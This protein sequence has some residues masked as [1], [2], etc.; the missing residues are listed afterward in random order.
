MSNSQPCILLCSESI[1]IV[2]DLLF[3]LATRRETGC[4]KR[5]RFTL[6]S[7]SGTT[8]HVSHIMFVSMLNPMLM[9]PAMQMFAGIDKNLEGPRH[10]LRISPSRQVSGPSFSSINQG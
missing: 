10:T 1:N 6:L 8:A 9:Q 3:E 7:W 4:V 5:E 2:G